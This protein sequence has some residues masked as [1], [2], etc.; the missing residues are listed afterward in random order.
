MCHTP[1]TTYSLLRTVLLF[2]EIAYGFIV[3]ILEIALAVLRGMILLWGVA[4][5]T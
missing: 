3:I 2:T 5:L 4:L 1:E